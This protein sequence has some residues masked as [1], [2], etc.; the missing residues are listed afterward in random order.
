[1]ASLRFAGRNWTIKA[2]FHGP[3][4]CHFSSNNAW[5]DDD[6]LLHLRIS[7]SE[8]TWYCA[9][10]FTTESFRFGDFQWRLICRPDRFDRNVVLGLFPYLGPDGQNEIDI[11]LARWGDPDNDPGNFTVWPATADGERTRTFPLN[12][13]G[14]HTTHRIHW[15]GDRVSFQMLGGHGSG[16][17]SPISQWTY[18][19][20]GHEPGVPQLPM[21]VHMN[22]WLYRGLAPYHAESTEV[23]IADFEYREP[24][25]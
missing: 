13:D 25:S 20:A 19:P 17:E 14:T 4:P 8:G 24:G 6:G 3:G 11:E 16:D 21:A 22:L 7:A 9:E 18:Q 5:V 23:V 2:G 15:S 10:V 12:L 1:M